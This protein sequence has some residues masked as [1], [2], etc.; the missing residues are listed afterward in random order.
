M[1]RENLAVTEMGRA[2]VN[3]N[4]AL[5]PA[6]AD[7]HAFGFSARRQVRL[8]NAGASPRTVTVVM[9]GQV[10]GQ[11]LPDR[12]YVLAAGADLLVPPFPPIYRQS[13]DSVWMNYDNPADVQV[14]VYE[15]PA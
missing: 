15:L 6:H 7:G 11:E 9:P 1:A 13:N 10:D 5:T 3:L 8:I 2:G 14:A 12:P 4:A